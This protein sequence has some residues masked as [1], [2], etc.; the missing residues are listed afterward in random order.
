MKPLNSNTEGCNPISSNCVIWQGPDIECIKLCKGDTVSDVVN[1]LATELCTILEYT[2]ITTYDLTC[3]ELQGCDPKDFPALIQLLIDRICNIPSTSGGGGIPVDDPIGRFGT[4]V[5]SGTCP[6]CVVSIAPCFYY[7]NEF[8]DEVTTMNLTDYARTVGTK[9]CEIVNQIL[10]INVI[11]TNHEERI[12]A[13]EDTPAPEYVLPQ[14]VPTCVLPALPSTLQDTLS[15]VEQQFCQLRLA[16][17]LPSQLLTSITL[18]CV[19]LNNSPTLGTSGS[20]MSSL[21]GW[22]TAV[23]N[24]SDTINNMWIT[25]CDLR[26]AVTN[27]QLT[28]CP[29]GCDGV[30]IN[31]SATFDGS[32]IVIYLTGTIPV[33]FADC[34][35]SGNLFTISD[36][37]GNAI[38]QRINVTSQ[39][40]SILGT[41]IIVSG[42]S[43]NLASD[44]TIH[45][46]ACVKNSTTNA[47]C[48]FCIDY[49]IDNTAVCPSLTIST[50]TDTSVNYSF[51]PF[52]V[53]ATYTVQLWNSDATLVLNQN[54]TSVLVAGTV[55]GSFN[56]LTPSTSYRLR[57]LVSNGVTTTECPYSII[58][59]LPVVCNAPTGV[60]GLV[61][62]PVECEDCGSALGFVSN[63]T[64][65]D[66]YYM[67]DASQ[68]LFLSSGGTFNSIYTDVYQTS[69]PGVVSP[70]TVSIRNSA[71]TASG[72]TYISYNDNSLASA[73]IIYHYD[74]TGTLVNTITLPF[75]GAAS[76][77][78]NAIDYS[79]FDGKIYFISWTTALL[80]PL[81]VYVLDP[82]D[83]SYTKLVNISATLV[84]FPGLR[85][86]PLNG[87][88][89]FPNNLGS[90]QI[91][92]PS[93]D[94]MINTGANVIPESGFPVVNES[95]GYVWIIRS[96]QNAINIWDVSG[97]TPVNV[98]TA[99]GPGVYAARTGS[100]NG[101]VFPMVYYPGDGT[102]GTDRMF[103]VFNNDPITATLTD[104]IEFN[105]TAPYTAT[106][107]VS[108]PF[109]FSP[110][111][112]KYTTSFNKVFLS[113]GNTIDAYAPTD[114]SVSF[115]SIT[116]A[117][118]NLM[119]PYEDTTNQQVV[120][121]NLSSSPTNN[122][123]WIGL[124]TT[125]AVFCS[126][127]LARYYD[128]SGPINN[129][130]YVWDD[131]TLSWIPAC[132]F[133]VIDSGSNFVVTA[134]FPGVT[135][136]SGVLLYS[137]TGGVTWKSLGA[138][139]TSS[140]WS[141]GVTYNKADIPSLIYDLRIAF[142]TDD[143]CGISSKIDN[144][145][146]P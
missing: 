3:L 118:T 110:V 22:I 74:S 136:Q 121:F 115:A 135:I 132:S 143:N 51:S 133:Q 54:V 14:V 83:D 128:M 140:Q 75:A 98:G 144:T 48:Q 77:R 27:I 107:F 109:Q 111:N 131:A 8:G 125:N 19:N 35:P 32:Q 116:T 64:A 31:I 108:L 97:V 60:I 67:D 20:T 90:T 91:G 33:G 37:S 78:C 86:N 63:P 124:D 100:A 80:N 2:S 17:G 39:I 45:T 96:N 15:A 70:S 50:T 53:P 13:L 57:I 93:T 134:T 43:L 95:N 76:I 38:S 69:V 126:Q 34:D 138:N 55:S 61:D 79:Q 146:N 85:T 56:T 52:A 21:P 11:L 84:G 113:Y 46:D 81:S 29:S 130:P 103:A 88:L 92:D 42:S 40:N 59:T 120:Y 112:L 101:G 44:F 12:T 99:N 105:A 122:L 117:G 18:Q 102:P 145:Y 62:L 71:T 26:V 41:S 6:D 119:W 49:V 141:T 114:G 73:S 23:T 5:V 1:K 123:Y 104:V 87:H 66:G 7:K 94:V 65:G 127:G 30:E 25:I 24:L 47:T 9:V 82:A 10:N 36:T 72:A 68:Y 58:T 137:T 129:G 139:N 106:I 4:G 28:C 89:M 142:L 16:T